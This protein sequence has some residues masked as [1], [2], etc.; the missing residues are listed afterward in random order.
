MAVEEIDNVSCACTSSV[1]ACSGLSGLISSTSAA[2]SSFLRLILVRDNFGI[3]VARRLEFGDDVG[4]AVGDVA[5][6]E[7]GDEEGERE[8]FGSS[9]PVQK[10]SSKTLAS[11]K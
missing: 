2:I 11:L 7:R 9:G 5:G 6:E 8:I 1:C 4:E 10:F 3:N